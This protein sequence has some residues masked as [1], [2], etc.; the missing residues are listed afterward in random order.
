MV[1]FKLRA[2][3]SDKYVKVYDKI[4]AQPH[5]PVRLE[6]NAVGSWEVE[7]VSEYDSKKGRVLVEVAPDNGGSAGTY[8]TV[9]DLEFVMDGETYEL[10]DSYL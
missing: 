3:E 7:S 9:K 4:A 8:K 2:L 1:Q 10:D 6:S 5:D